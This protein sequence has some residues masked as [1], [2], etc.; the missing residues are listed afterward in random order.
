MRTLSEFQT[1]FTI[2][3]D[4]NKNIQQIFIKEYMKQ[5]LLTIKLFNKKIE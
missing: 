1:H 3:I 5:K 4:G 2:Y